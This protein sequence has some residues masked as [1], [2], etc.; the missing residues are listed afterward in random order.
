M[1]SVANLLSTLKSHNIKLG[2]D[3]NENILIRG[4]RKNLAPELIRQIKALKPNLVS[5]LKEGKNNSPKPKISISEHGKVTLL[6]YAQQ[7]LWLLDQIDGGSAHYNIHSVLHLKGTLD[8]AVLNQVFTTILERHESLRTCFSKAGDGEPRQIIQVVRDFQVTINDLSPLDVTIN[9]VRVG[10]LLQA[11]AQQSFDLSRDLMLRAQLIKLSDVEWLLQVTLHH[12][13]AD[14]WS[15]GL[16]VKE[17]ITLYQAYCDCQNNPLPP[18][19]LQYKDYAHWQRQWLQGEVLDQQL[20]YWRKQLHGIPMVHSLP[21]D[22]LR[23]KQ[24]SFNGAT[25]STDL[26]AAVTTLLKTQCQVQ[27]A[28]LFMGLHAAF[29]V[30]LARYSNETDIVV[31]SPIANREQ[32]E[33]EGLIGFFVNNLVLRSDLSDNPNFIALLQQSKQTLLDAYAHQQV[34]FEQLVETLQPERSLSHSPLFQIML[35]LQNNEQG[36]LELPDLCITPV[37]QTKQIAKYDLT[38]T[39]VEQPDGHGLSLDWEYNTDLFHPESI[40]RLAAHFKTLLE[41]LLNEPDTNVYQVGLLNKKEQ[42]QLLLDWNNTQTDYP[43]EKCIH[44]LFEEQVSNNPDAIALV[45]EEQQLS[46][47]QLNQRANQLAHYLI[48]EKQIK[49]DTLVGICLERSLEL[50]IAILGILK[51]GGAY[52]PLDPTYPEARLAHMIAD[53]ELNT[54]LTHSDLYAA[55]PINDAQALCLDTTETQRVVN[56]QAHSNPNLQTLDL[57]SKHLAYVIYTSGSTGKPKGVMVEH[58]ALVNRITWMDQEYGSGPNDRF[59]QKTPYSFDVS[60][61]EFTWPLSVGACLVMAKPE[62]HKDPLY[63]TELIQA[64]H[65]S[66]LHFVPAM[67]DSFLSLGDL[68]ACPSLKQVF[69]SGEALPPQQVETCFKQQPKVELHNLY[70]PTE[71][72][73]DVSYWNCRQY[74]PTQRSIPIGRPIHNIQ[75]HVL[76]S[77]HA[78]APIGAPGELHIGGVGLARGYLNNPKLTAE[79]FIENPYYDPNNPSSSKHLYRTGDLVR[80]LPDGNLEFL[81]RI[82]QQVKVRGFRIELGEIE[83][84]LATHELIKDAIVLAKG[85]ASDKRLV[86][87]VVKETA[88]EG[89]T[90]T[91]LQ[92]QLQQHLAQQLPDYMVPS[93]FVFLD[94]MPLTPNGKID[95]K[96]LPEPD[97]SEQQAEYV[98]PSTELEKTLCDIWQEVLGVERV[99]L[100]DN[101][102]RLGGHS[103][104][105]TRLVS[106]INDRLKINLSLKS[107]FTSTTLAQLVVVVSELKPGNQRPPL[108]HANR[109]EPL[110]LSYAQQRLWLLDQIDGGSTHYHIP[111]ALR[112]SGPLNDTALEQAFNSIL[113]RHE[114]LRTCFSLDADKQPQQIIQ[115]AN[116][117]E[118]SLQDLSHLDAV[119][120]TQ[121]IDVSIEAEV[122]RPFD[123]SCD[124]MLRAGLIKLSTNDHILVVTLHHIAADG[125]S[126]RLLINEFSQLYQAYCQNK[127]NPLPPL[128]IQ[129]ADYAQWQRH[130][131]QGEVLEQ[132]LSYWQ[133][134]LHALPVV[135]NLPLDYPRPSIQ[136]F[137]GAVHHSNLE[138]DLTQ[139]LK[140]ITE[141]QGA[142]LFMGL[143][144]AF[145]VLLAR[146]SNETDIVVG[147]PIANREQHEIEGLIGFFVNN[148][149]LRS[150]LSE[151]PNFVELLQ[152]SKQTLLDAYAHQQV[153]FEQLV[154]TLQPERSLSHSPLFQIMLVLQNN[155]QGVL[156]LPDLTLTPVEHS[157]HIAKYD[158]TLTVQE[159]APQGLSLIWEYNTDLFHPESIARL[160]E[161]F[162]T[163]L[164][165]LLKEPDTN[166]YQVDLLNKK[167]QQQLLV[168]WNETKT[169]YPKDTC[170]HEL[171]EEQ[172]KNNPD[173]IALVFEEQQLSYQQLNQRANQ[174]AHYLITE[175]QIKPDTLIGICLERS[176]EMVVAILGVLKAGGAYVPL[177]PA[178]PEARLAHMIVDA[179]LNTIVT[180]STL[181]E[182]L[183]IKD[184]HA[185]CLD[186]DQ[187][188][189]LLKKQSKQNPSGKDLGLTANHLAY[190]IYTSGS[191]GTP[192]GVMV[193]HHNV[194]RLMAQSRDYFDFT[195]QDRWTLFHSYAFDFSVWELWGALSFGGRLVVVPYWVSRSS[196]DFYRL[197]QQ[198][199]ITVLNQTP[200]AFNALIQEDQNQVVETAN[201]LALRYVIFGGE[202][203][204]FNALKPWFDKHGDQQPELINMYGITE[205]TVHVTYRRLS[206]NSL[207]KDPRRSL[208]G[209]PLKDLGVVLL[210]PAQQLVPLGVS[211]ELYVRGGG[212]SRGYLNRTEL[213]DDRFVQLPKLSPGERYYRTGDLARYT[214]EGDLDY[215]GRIDHQVKIRGFRIELGEIETA[216]STHPQ[217]KDVIILAKGEASDKRLVAYVAQETAQAGDTSTDLQEQLQQHLAQQ[218]PDYMIPS[219][220]VVLEKFPLTPNGKI[221]R[222]SLPEPDF[223][224]RQAEYLAPQTELE[225]MLCDI[226]QTVL[227]VERVGL[228][229]NFFQLGGHSLLLMQVIARLQQAGFSLAVRDLF[230]APTLGALASHIET[231]TE[232]RAAVFQAPP[233]LIPDNCEK[234][235]PDLLPLIALTEAELEHIVTQVPGG[236]GNIQDI[237]PLGPLQAGILY[238]HMMNLERDPYVLPAVFKIKNKSVLERFLDSLRQIVERHDVLR[239]AILWN[240]LSQPVQVVHRQVELPVTWLDSGDSA[241]DTDIAVLKQLQADDSSFAVQ[242]MDLS[243]APLIKID[244]I[245]KDKTAPIYVRICFHHIISDH[246]GLEIVYHEL[247][248]HLQGQGA[249]LPNT[250]PYREFIAHSQQQQQHHDAKTYFETTL[251]DLDEPSVPFNLSNVRGDGRNIETHRQTLPLDTSQELRQHAKVLHVSPAS[252]FHA[253]WALVVARCSGRDDLVFGTV[254][255]GRLQGTVGVEQMLGVFINTLPLRVTLKD[256]PVKAFVQ[257]VHQSLQA[258]LPYEQTSLAFA[259]Q[260]SGLPSD[261][262]L[263]SALFNYRHSNP[264][265]ASE[266]AAQGLPGVNYLGVEERTNY[267]FG[268]SVD[269]VGEGQA[270][271]L[272]TQVDP[273]IGAERIGLYMQTAVEELI[274]TLEVNPNQVTT[275]LHC[276]PQAERQQLLVEWNN[277]QTDYPK[278]KCIHQLFEEQVNNNPDAIALVFEDQQLSYQQLNERANQLAHYLVNQ[279]HVKPDTLIG[280][281][282]DRSLEIVVAILG[283]MKAGGAYVPLDPTYPEARLVHMIK[284]AGLNTII[285]HRALLDS[286]PINAQ[287]ALCLDTTETQDVL[288]EQSTHNP[289]TSALG[290]SPNH[291][292]YVIYTSGSTGKPKGV[293]IPHRGWVNTISDNAAQ[294]KL[295][296]S[297]VFLQSTSINFDAASWV[298]GMGL[299][300]GASLVIASAEEQRGQGL[301]ECVTHH[302]ITH[303]MMTPSGL[304]LLEPRE[305]PSIKTV[306]VGGEACH[307]EIP[308]RWCPYTDFYNAYGPTETSI[309]ASVRKISVDDLVVNIG[310][311]ISNMQAYLLDKQQ[312]LVPMGVAGELHLGGV[313]LARGYLNRPELTVAKFI[314]NPYYDKNNPNSSNRLYKT[315]DLVRWLPDGNLDFLGRIDDQ[316]KIHGFRVELGEIENSLAA[317]ASIKD[318]TVLAKGEEN[319]KR[320]V[321]YVVA[322]AESA[323][324]T[325]TLR[326]YLSVM[327]PSYMIPAAF[328]F[329]KEMPLTPNGKVDHKALPDPDLERQQAEYIAP[330]TEAEKTLCTIWQDVLGLDRVGCKD[331]FFQL[332]GHS[333]LIM[334]VIT[335]MQQV[336]FSLTIKDFFAAQ[337]LSEL[338]VMM[339]MSAN[340]SIDS[341]FLAPPNLIQKECTYLTP[342]LL[343]LVTLNTDELDYIVG[344]VPG[345]VSNIQDIYS[346]GPLQEGILY[347]HMMNPEGDP[348]ILPALFK[349]RDKKAWDQFLAALQ[350]VVERH[351][352][353]RTAILWKNLSKPVQVV[354]RQADLPVTCVDFESDDQALTH[355]EA[356]SLAETQTMDLSKASLLKIDLARVK[357][358]AHIYVLIRFHHIISD[359]VGLDIVYQELA[360]YMQGLGEKLLSPIAYREYIAHTQH[361]NK[362]HNAQTYFQEVLGDLDEPT[363]PFGLSNV[364]GNGGHINELRKRLPI[365]LGQDIRQQAKVLKVTPASLFHA[366][367]ALV[368]GCCSGRDDIVFGT[369]VSGRLQGTV[370]AEHML[371]VFINTLPLRV[372]LND[373]DA[374]GLVLQVH[375]SLQALLPYEQ[376]SLALAQ[377]CSNFSGGTPLFSALL[378]YRHSASAKK[379]GSQ[380]DSEAAFEYIG[381]QERTN[382]PF[383]LSV[384]DYGDEFEIDVKVDA[385]LKAERIAGYVEATLE[386][387]VTYIGEQSTLAVSD[388]TILSKDERQQLLFDWNATAASY[389]KDKCI[390]QLFETQVE[391]DPHAIAVVYGDQRLSYGELNRRANQLAHLLV[392]QN[393]VQPDVL[394]GICL[395]RSLEMVIAILGVLKSGAA[396]VSLDPEYP[397]ARTSYMTQDAN[398]NVVITASALLSQGLIN[399][400][401]AFCL[402]SKSV[403]QQLDSQPTSNLELKQVGLSPDHLAYVIYTSGSTGK[404][405]GVMVAHSS[406]VNYVSAISQYCKDI[407]ASVVNTNIGYDGTATSFWLPLVLGKRVELAVFSDADSL[408]FLADELSN[409]REA[410]LFKI[411]P[412]HLEVLVD[413]HEGFDNEIKH[414]VFVGGE[415]FLRHK[416]EALPQPLKAARI[417][418]HYGP[419]ETA[420]GCAVFYIDASLPLMTASIPLGRPI[421]N[422]IALVLNSSGNLCPVG[423]VGELHVGGVGLARGYLNRAEL[424]AEKFIRNP[425]F[426][427]ERSDTGE[428]LYKTGDLVRWLPGGQLEFLGRIDHQVKIRGF[429]IE[430]GEIENNLSA[431]DL[432]HESI[433]VAKKNANGGDQYLVAYVVANEGVLDKEQQGDDSADEMLTQ[434][435]S[436]M[437]KLQ[438]YLGQELPA[439][440][441]PSTFVFLEKIPLTA[442]GKA[443][444]QSLPEPDRKDQQAVYRAPETETQKILCE[445]WQ[446]VLGVER[447]GVADNFFQLGGHSLLATR[448]L[449]LVCKHFDIEIEMKEVFAQQDVA[450]LSQIVDREL[451]FKTGVSFRKA[452]AADMETSKEAEVWEI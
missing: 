448:L 351:D 306:I 246:V 321:A 402:D 30:L 412:A 348:Y 67:L 395:Q 8:E 202:A 254:V 440:M 204:V 401:Q 324:L 399:E 46:Y 93:V 290:L 129:Y 209:K 355:L 391:R 49:P 176:L 266:M 62:G 364:Q 39:V 37:P 109:K 205:T 248:K 160:A 147:S 4:N 199:R 281:C 257:N 172:V 426:D 190:V 104:L 145:S 227:G 284:D 223:S 195:D 277:T 424:T 314:N 332:G 135:H 15:M 179:E 411:T 134:Q 214:A 56:Q 54:V 88:Q 6:S 432:V 336:G 87:Y 29:S 193:S 155:E 166:V 7:R 42:Q 112:L 362:T 180:H 64:Q 80:W 44:Q 188:Q 122:S 318:V 191:T 315:G 244:L 333:L 405:K 345:G 310:K 221:D 96:A 280:I 206:H 28:T 445:I 185:L 235:T 219:V 271:E 76:N 282:L 142:T 325:E 99:G 241:F 361:Q 33:I 343:P 439:Y 229:D 149:V 239:T 408:S 292:A 394:I 183:P 435:N 92:E 103:L 125:W 53:A 34:P 431:H 133:K 59:L 60:V 328:V 427:S 447:V 379:M 181:L 434:R 251:G 97:F 264:N 272:D 341:I 375:R 69:C 278:E 378:N 287:Q 353:L 18:L 89:E 273:S 422:V 45:F 396:Y 200:S 161:H 276:L 117:F 90:A 84:T 182:G 113:E 359:H 63:L 357:D 337:D 98:A 381:G 127:Q 265:T 289:D 105:A 192:K 118:V 297:S 373:I 137:K 115:A 413:A 81:G 388:I 150:D 52:V 291:L 74:Q 349:V 255:S 233:S 82:D 342:D 350:F 382:Y 295:D 262:P 414:T 446:Q 259:Q 301:R 267:P 86:A 409:S 173:A 263:F 174:L 368:V 36:T 2:L 220:F 139:A 111:G 47:Q 51:A 366:A 163:L 3:E 327:L 416:Y 106:R 279:K 330:R 358:N 211:G 170:I 40:A 274:T 243:Q 217:I 237:Y 305:I 1:T 344:Q 386:G 228:S 151:Q 41:G 101:F 31:G 252:L 68:S 320:L 79:T 61:W 108:T 418:N 339:D 57:T 140:R 162:K 299:S 270:F 121:Q 102:F 132:Q 419:S 367:W 22:K 230:G 23:P 198:E 335:R 400:D 158:L 126:M 203:L 187:T 384:D 27:G 298:I 85:E 347:H 309:C 397:Q 120:Q 231:T 146:Y 371:G 338:A 65:I 387:L 165:G 377:Q 5:L 114:S 406:L 201:K 300:A 420:V 77:E 107:L 212:V 242:V 16:L 184:Q 450:A 17:F 208:I 156:E 449:T 26:G 21:L 423:V 313:G 218:L 380:I 319:D 124:L 331:N 383:G 417:F 334:Q 256:K 178:Y 438:N 226:W 55:T 269:D 153:P 275:T 392:A 451:K 70:G 294:F 225:K 236:V 148:L 286:L 398:L 326:S 444:R 136:T 130:W 354:Y 285:T 11:G 25:C 73:I 376:A 316:V 131:L 83:N 253:A 72:A 169:D 346:L 50:V 240:D 215:L 304:M 95:R 430:L 10:I 410:K 177:D 329:L 407:V 19:V 13:A 194:Y 94:A 415:L 164:E 78:L 360:Q 249:Q 365:K 442:N 20:R 308:A 189:T 234:I 404:P 433:V 141:A 452:E 302:Q 307:T 374:A 35:V 385:S 372:Q 370:G 168:E 157:H 66:K 119:N 323:T 207:E 128:A 167:E 144:A 283:V 258:L 363:F 222:K 12:I 171:F 293:M 437:E 303:L 48:T 356:R 250:Y 238:H 159:T 91:D 403:Q 110:V 429:R 175:K 393:T 75:L 71:A 100:N 152:Q 260:C 247:Q 43:K 421:Q 288:K 312:Q 210:N 213:T 311:P 369:V 322:K 14:G 245:Q 317:H 38:L 216:L 24:Q 58:Q 268:L 123:L 441:V 261:T 197:L 389:P 154:E 443:D 436:F 143:H 9:D 196:A 340:S 138:Q 352:V 186:T 296:A 428:Y 116:Q 425:Y 390:H 32:H 224:G 232:T